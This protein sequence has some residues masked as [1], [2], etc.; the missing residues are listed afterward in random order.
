MNR[1][2]SVGKRR[3]ERLPNQIYLFHGEEDYLIDEK[4]SGLKKGIVNPSL[5]V[6]QIEGDEDNLPKIISALQTQPFFGGDKLIIIY[7]IDLKSKIWEP[8]IESLKIISPGVKVVFWAAAVHRASKIYK[9]LD[10]AG[11]V[12]EFKAF[13]DW[14]QDELVRWIGGRVKLA[15]KE[16]DQ[17]AAIELQ[18]ICGN[19]L[20]KLSSEIEK[21]VTYL[22]DRK[23]IGQADVEALASAGVKNTFALS[24]A[25]ADKDLPRSLSTLEVLFRNKFQVFPLLALMASQFRTMLQIKGLGAAGRN[26]GYAAQQLKA[27]PYFVRKCMEKAGKFSAEELKRNLNLLLETDLKLKS[28]EPQL[29]TLTVLLTS[30]CGK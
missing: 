26:A 29:N 4:I 25:L 19:R 3:G 23:K 18:E 14:Q 1:Q 2:R 9:F 16:I 6:E 27:S 22:G 13:A 15:G 28:G 17:S 12:C 8:L 21:L 7:D 5:N 24:D 10:N 30:L 11:E 20:R